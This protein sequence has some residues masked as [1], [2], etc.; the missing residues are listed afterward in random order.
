MYNW[1][2]PPGS[3]APVVNATITADGLIETPGVDGAVNVFDP[4]TGQHYTRYPGGAI[5]S[6]SPLQVNPVG[7]PQLPGADALESQFVAQDL[8][9]LASTILVDS[10]FSALEPHEPA[11]FLGY[12]DFYI[13]AM[14]YLYGLSQ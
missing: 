3:V 1:G 8:K 14:I 12:M 13:N 10:Q 11:D 7:V 4:A 9:S 2:Q 5:V 6:A